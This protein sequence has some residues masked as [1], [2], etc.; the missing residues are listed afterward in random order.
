MKIMEGEQHETVEVVKEVDKEGVS[1]EWK[2]LDYQVYLGKKKGYK[3]ILKGVSGKANPGEVLAIMGP[4]GSGKSTLLSILSGMIPSS[5]I[6]KGSVLANGKRLGS[7]FT[8][9]VAGFV[10]QDDLLFSNLTVSESIR[11]SGNLRLPRSL[12]AAEK[13]ERVQNVIAELGLRKVESTYIGGPMVRGVSGGERKRVS[14]ALELIRDVKVLLLDEPTSGLD[15]FMAYNVMQTLRDLARTKNITVITTIHQPRSQIWSMFDKLLLLSEGEAMFSGVA[16]DALDYFARQGY[17]C[18]DL[19]NPAD[20]VLDLVSIDYRSK[21][22]EEETKKRVAAL[23]SAFRSNFGSEKEEPVEVETP[24]AKTPL[25]GAKIEDVGHTLNLSPTAKLSSQFYYLAERAIKQ[26]ARDKLSTMIKLFQT[27]FFTL[28]IGFVYFQMGNDQQSIQNRAGLLFFAVVN[29]SLGNIFGVIPKFVQEK[30]IFRREQK[31]GFYG[32]LSYFVGKNLAELPLTTFFPFLFATGVYWMTG[33]QTNFFKYVIFTGSLMLCSA[34]AESL[35]LMMGAI[36]PNLIVGNVAGL[37][38]GIVFMIFGGLYVNIDGL[39]IIFKIVSAVS[40]IN[41]TYTIV[42]VNE[43]TGLTF[44]CPDST[45]IVNEQGVSVCR[46]STGEQVLQGFSLEDKSIG[47][48]F[49]MLLVLF[50]AYRILAYFAL[51]ITKEKIKAV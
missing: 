25:K 22:A 35:G 30:A 9:K 43:F 3:T 6:L 48:N 42:M 28:L 12:T 45:K 44:T 40:L 8:K 31:V 17:A 38:V 51:R 16:N 26:I 39:F 4:S 14:I 34:T 27:V 20:F 11:F 23:S 7:S 5:S 36:V 13:E 10:E 15:S 1:V 47:F 2:D 32:A 41:Y 37:L 50:F 24:D 49:G 29:Q 33:L 46:V 21:E 19:F 18:P